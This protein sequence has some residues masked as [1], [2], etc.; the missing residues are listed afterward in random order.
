MADPRPLWRQ[1]FDAAEKLVGPPLE[2][3]VR[4][5]EFARATALGLKAQAALTHRANQVAAKLWH[6][7]NLPA[8]TDVLRLRAQVGALDREV[9]RL[10][11]R[12]EQQQ[13]QPPGAAGSAPGSAAAR[14]AAARAAETDER[15]DDGV[16][17][18]PARGPRTHP[19]RS[20]TRGQTRRPP[21][22]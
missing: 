14:S 7:V 19:E 1:A 8:G 11:L 13:Q 3:V 10:T 4:T 21:G 2:S 15:T 6:L 20:R 16:A 17:A 9:R 5:D 22:P 18:E 12:L